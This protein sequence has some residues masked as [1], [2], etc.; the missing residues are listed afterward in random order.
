[1]SQLIGYVILFIYFY[2]FYVF[3]YVR[4]MMVSYDNIK[5]VYAKV[6]VATSSW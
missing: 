2:L 6:D 4:H 3:V 5:L 1:M